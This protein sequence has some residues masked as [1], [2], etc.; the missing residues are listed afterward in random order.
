MP[1]PE[2]REPVLKPLEGSD[3]AEALI[4][5]KARGEH[6]PDED[7]AALLDDMERLGLTGTEAYIALDE[8]RPSSTPAP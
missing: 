5:K 6:V 7:I 8:H 2:T 4:A 1:F 3:L